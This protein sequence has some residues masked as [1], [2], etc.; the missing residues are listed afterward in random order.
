MQIYI[1]KSPERN[2]DL[3]LQ[4]IAS[5]EN[6]AIVQDA[7]WAKG[8]DSEEIDRVLDEEYDLSYT[9]LQIGWR[10]IENPEGC[11]FII[12]TSKQT[13][14]NAKTADSHCRPRF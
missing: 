5:S 11:S 2:I 6:S 12:K 7:V 1:I 10:K 3:L 9:E 14:N 13:H 8:L 4:A